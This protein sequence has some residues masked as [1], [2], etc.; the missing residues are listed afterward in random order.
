MLGDRRI[1]TVEELLGKVDMNYD[2]QL[3]E[4]E[5]FQRTSH[6]LDAYGVLYFEELKADNFEID[7]R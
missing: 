4:A 5:T 6:K 3:A 7:S 1:V 2:W